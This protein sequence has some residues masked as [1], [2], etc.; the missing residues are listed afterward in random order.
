[1]LSSILTTAAPFRSTLLTPIIICTIYDVKARANLSIEYFLF[2]L[3][4]CHDKK[5]IFT[6]F[7]GI[8]KIC[9]LL[10]FYSTNKGFYFQKQAV[11]L[12]KSYQPLHYLC[13]FGRKKKNDAK[14]F[15]R[16]FPLFI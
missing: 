11:Y 13:S 10:P 7:F 14:S 16:V 5:H 2:F 15:F 1:M 12:K 3:K 8:L 4:N 9:S 6:L